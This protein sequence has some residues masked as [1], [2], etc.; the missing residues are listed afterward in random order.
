MSI[1]ADARPKLIK[2]LLSLTAFCLII[3]SG[4]AVGPDYRR[5]ETKVPST[6]DGQNAVTPANPSQ[7]TLGPATLVEWWTAFNDPALSS[8]VDMAVRANLDVRLAE[9]RIRQARATRGVVGAPLW[10]GIDASAL[11]QRSKGSS[12]VGGGGAIATAGGLRNLWQAGLD[13]T[14]EIDIF[15]GTRRNVEAATAD[16]QAAVED[17]RDVMITLVGDVGSNY[18]NLRGFQQQIEIARRNLKAQ[19]HNAAIIQ[20]RH[21]AGFV[22][23]LDVANAKAQ[24]ATTEATI[25]VFESSAR[26]AIYS[27]GVLLG[28][29][30]AALTQDLAQA[31]PIPPTPLEIPV[32]LPSELLR[33][34]PDIRRAEAQL[35][36]ATARIGVATADLFPKFNLAGTFG[37]SASDVGRLDKWNS[38]FW[39]WGPSVTWPIFAGGRIYYNIKVQ[40]ALTEQAL[41]T[42]EKTVLTALKEVETALVAYAK[43]QETR[44]SLSEAV[45][46]NRKAVDLASQLYL[47]GKSDF[48]NVL[49][50]QR[51]LF[52]SEDALARSTTTVDTNL[53]ALY[54]ALGGGW[55]KEG[56]PPED[57][58][59]EK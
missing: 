30:P 27:L 37:L 55:E 47:A 9:A 40:D 54:K 33:R 17:R 12:E 49:I 32:G 41:L 15:G 1:T 44:K 59:A 36:A 22:G 48:L 11:Y 21:D 23:G 28:R 13:A 4:C 26:A 46:N 57:R 14:W 10:P 52:T 53:I 7:T 50:A 25:P 18:I 16:L 42:Y 45:V 3:V 24:V 35:H 43:Q 20:K 5:P 38:N 58:K 2:L 39:S 29:E 8:L 34:R 19:K 6:W 51:S 56:A 31:A